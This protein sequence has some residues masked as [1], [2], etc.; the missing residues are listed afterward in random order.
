MMQAQFRAGQSSGRLS[1]LEGLRGLAAM[2]V[3]AWHFIWAFAPWQL[4]SVAGLPT[5]GMVGSPVAASIDGPA[6][7]A[8]FFVLSGFVLPL[9]LF[10]SGRVRTAI[11]AAAKRWLRLAGLS[12]VAVLS[13]YA[14]FRL[15]LFRYRE[16]AGLTGS[17]WLGS[18]GGGDPTGRFVPSLTGALSEG[19]IGAFVW[20]SDAYNPVLWT[21][22]HE[23]FG[24]FVSI[25]AV[26]ATLCVPRWA[27]RCILALL[28]VLVP[29]A[30]PWLIPFVVGTGLAFLVWRHG[31]RL[32][33]GAA[34]LSIV[35]GLFLFG[36]LEPTGA[37]AGIPVIQDSAGYRYDRILVHTL[38][39]LL[40]LL[41]LIGN[42]EASRVLR[43]GPLLLL[44][45]LSFPIYLF[46]FPLM[47]S[48][49]CGLF[50]IF[51]GRVPY[52]VG[53]MLVAA[54]YLPVV[55]LL[56]VLFA[57]VD[58]A[59]GAWVNRFTDRLLTW[60]IGLARVWRPRCR[61]TS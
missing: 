31:A 17:T 52:G 46:H 14:L 27:C 10:R 22:R 33:P 51:H 39:A 8:L 54:I 26:L 61:G 34:A 42:E 57:R 60:G 53:L 13:C 48:L 16:A 37:Y 9:G 20:N 49:A 35:A 50:F 28:V 4:G 12:V 44:G 38:S 47:C 55:L 2:M 6:A 43:T 40:I 25:G 56:A 11:Q 5:S 32:G 29:L 59:W 15:D 24:S 58:E 19:L 1:Q 21:M 36:Y 30:D 3:V 41:G 23:L 7:V 45:R 18:Y